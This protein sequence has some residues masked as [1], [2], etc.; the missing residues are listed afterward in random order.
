MKNNFGKGFEASIKKCRGLAASLLFMALFISQAIA[1]EFQVQPTTMDLG[2][3]V[4]SGAFS[5][6]NNGNDKIDF[7]VSAKEWNQDEKGK[8]VYVDTKEIV[9]FP[10]VMSV[11]ANS[12][13]AIRIGLKTPPSAREKTYR[14]FVEEIPTPKKTQ[15]EDIKKNVKAGLTIAFRFSMPIFVQPLKPQESYAL[16]RIEMSK[17]TV[18]AIVKNTGNVHVKLR[19]VKFSGKAADGKELFSKEVAG[20]YILNGLSLSYEA[21]VPKDICGKLA[22]IEVNA[23]TENVNIDGKLAVQKSM[24]TQ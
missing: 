3:R 6:I 23:Q 8:D 1:A 21:V 15:D 24:C 5:V 4:K 2:A 9:F 20:W 16:D 22:T 19:A 14:L 12:Q 7:Q 18:K 11:E 10:K 17:G 13:R